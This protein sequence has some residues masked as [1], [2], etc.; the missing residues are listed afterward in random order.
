MECGG[1]GP[2]S[3]NAEPGFLRWSDAR[4]ESRVNLKSRDGRTSSGEDCHESLSTEKGKGFI[5]LSFH[6]SELK[7]NRELVKKLQRFASIRYAQ[8][9]Q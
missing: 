2:M 7:K 6:H 4:E 9:S 3:S 1:K 8:G 5:I